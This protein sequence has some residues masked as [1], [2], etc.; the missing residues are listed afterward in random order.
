MASVLYP[1]SRPQSIGE[2]LDAA[3][4]IYRVTLLG[5]LPFGVLA[6]VAGQLPNI[7]LIARHRPLRQFGGGDPLWFVL[8]GL[9]VF[10][11]IAFVNV[12]V[13]RQGSAMTGSHSAR[14]ALA[15][16][17][18]KAPATFMAG[19]LLFLAVG[20]CFIPLAVLPREYVKWGFVLLCVPATYVGVVLSCCIIAVLVGD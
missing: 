16:G 3:F 11:S 13:L 18:R 6:I 12:I 1:P 9:G 19:I 2:V 8:Y 10:L 17:V 20:A 14:R 7:Y 5:C 4:R 15:A